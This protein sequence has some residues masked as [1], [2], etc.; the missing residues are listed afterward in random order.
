MQKQLRLLALFVLGTCAA[1]GDESPSAAS[2][3][4]T[5]LSLA[6]MPSMAFGG[7][8]ERPEYSFSVVSAG[9]F[10]GPD[11]F[12]ILDSQASELKVYST[13]GEHLHTFGRWGDGPGE[14]DR[15]PRLLAMGNGTIRIWDGLQQR[16]TVF[17]G[18]GRHRASG[19]T[20]SRRWGS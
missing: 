7:L 8:E 9:A 14:L 17:D 20:N 16:L 6:S 15:L 13:S 12:V 1:D 11:R 18:E 2:K 19:G 5:P 3:G 10:L 4:P